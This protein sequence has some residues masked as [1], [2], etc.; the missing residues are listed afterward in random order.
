M[1]KQA[2]LIRSKGVFGEGGFKEYLK[3]HIE[4]DRKRVRK[5][6]LREVL[7]IINIRMDKGSGDEFDNGHEAALRELFIEV[8]MMIGRTGK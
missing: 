1:I 4:K 5:E 8:A 7:D 3:D 2:L 6:T